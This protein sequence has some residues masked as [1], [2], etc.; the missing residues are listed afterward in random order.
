VENSRAQRGTLI[1]TLLHMNGC[2]ATLNSPPRGQCSLGTPM[3]P[4]ILRHPTDGVRRDFSRPN[5][6]L[7]K[8]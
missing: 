1:A 7:R 6:L 8:Q 2:N 4:I 3:L 5:S